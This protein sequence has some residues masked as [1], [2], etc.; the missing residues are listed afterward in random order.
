[1]RSLILRFT[2]LALLVPS[3][4]VSPLAVPA[5]AVTADVM[6]ME[7][8]TQQSSGGQL[9]Q[10]AGFTA[11]GSTSTTMAGGAKFTIPNTLRN[12]TVA[13]P[14][15]TSFVPGQTYGAAPTATATTAKLAFGSGVF[16]TA[17]CPTS[18]V[19]T[20]AGTVTVHAAQYDD[21]GAL[22][23]LAADYRGTCS[24]SSGAKE[25]VAGSVR[26]NTTT[27]W[28]TLRPV[29]PSDTVAMGRERVS[30][31]TISATGSG[32]SVQLGQ[33]TIS[34]VRTADYRV[35]DNGC[36]G[37]TLGD[38]ESCQLDVSFEPLPLTGG[39]SNRRVALLSV[40]TV[41]HVVDPVRVRLDSMTTDVPAAPQTVT[42]Y[43]T[44]NGVGVSWA[45]GWPSAQQYRLERR[46][47]GDTAWTTVATIAAGGP[48]NH[49]DH[50][51]EPGQEVEYRVT[52]ANAGWDGGSATTSTTRPM[53]V[54][55]PGPNTLVAYGSNDAAG[56]SATIRDGIDGG[57]VT[58]W[59][60]DLPTIQATAG[61]TG[62]A[63]APALVTY[64][65]PVVPGPG[66][67]RSGDRMS[68]W[69]SFG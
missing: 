64:R 2:V 11:Y 21:A 9:T 44:A 34:G 5:S 43:P 25:T 30:A 62:T 13:P 36:A 57:T 16:S 20:F 52:G 55:S 53:S 7:W 6:S 37:T 33:A 15:G 1:M 65:V 29:Y 38:G 35:S 59:S 67:Y 28:L 10:T 39:G 46:L 50:D 18:T 56:P 26:H 68:G 63:M 31:V 19:A 14:T 12:V 58:T 27:P 61:P 4:A 48:Y 51:T 3:A 40:A 41:G 49:V 17:L 45:E 22:T 54:P 47:S 24:L 8:Q 32:K 60:S 69:P 23:E 66:E 42:T